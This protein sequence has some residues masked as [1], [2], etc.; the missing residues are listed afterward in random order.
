[1]KRECETCV[2]NK[3]IYCPSSIDCL[4]TDDKPYYQ[5]RIMLLEENWKLKKQLEEYELSLKISKEVLDLQGQD[6]NYNY[7]SYMLGM[8]NGMEYIIALFEK[9]EPIYKDGKD[10]DFL[11]DKNKNQQKEFMEWLES[12]SHRL[13][14]DILLNSSFIEVRTILLKYK[15]I[16]GDKE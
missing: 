4:A 16:I 3:L 5:N 8:Y 1:M 2:R 10:I 6:G 13:S 9:R 14:G 7:D 15:E 11:E 12:E